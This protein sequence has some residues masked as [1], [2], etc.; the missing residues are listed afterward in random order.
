MMAAADF[1]D[2]LKA[3]IGLNA[4]CSFAPASSMPPA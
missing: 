2:L 1:E 3:S 4:I